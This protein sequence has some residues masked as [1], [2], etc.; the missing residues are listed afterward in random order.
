MTNYRN[1]SIEELAR[2]DTFRQWVLDPTIEI[3]TFWE[4]WMVQNPDRHATVNQATEL[5][6]GI[7][8]KY[9]DDLSDETIRNEITNLVELA[10]SDKSR[11]R[12]TFLN[13]PVF[14]IAAMLTL[15]AGFGYFYF[16]NHYT[17]KRVTRRENTTDVFLITKR[18]NT[19]K[20][21]TILLEDGSIAT[22]KKGS[23]LQFPAKFSGRTRQVLLT[24]EAFFD[25]AK[26]A[27]KPFLVFANETVTRVLGTSFRIKAIEGDNTIMVVV[28][29]GKVSVYPEKEYETLLSDQSHPQITGVVLR[30][31]QQVVFNIKENSL[32]KGIVESPDMLSESSSNQELIFDDEP[33]ANVLNMFKVMYGIDKERLSKCPISTIF[34][35]ENLKQRINAICQTIGATYEVVNGQII[36]N[37]KGCNH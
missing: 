6:L 29:T 5:L 33:V 18:N 32:K 2:D 28:K 37:S 27:D 9:K 1:F 19:I 14:R 23:T 31:N 8:E 3:V 34:K 30:P 16:L 35:E 13:N 10:E 11:I 12:K 22:L 21:M 17:E 24:G 36:L 26:N 15:L 7:Q 25:V 20:E 4:N